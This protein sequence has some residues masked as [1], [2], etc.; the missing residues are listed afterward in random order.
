[1]VRIAELETVETMTVRRHEKL[2]E[3][4]Q[5]HAE[6]VYVRNKTSRQNTDSL[7]SDVKVL[8]ARSEKKFVERNL[9][10]ARV[11][12]HFRALHTLVNADVERKRTVKNYSQTE[13]CTS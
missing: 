2:M 6:E 7:I 13:C 11:E 5:R 4:K 1:M 3:V 12:R 8:K 10:Q 9:I